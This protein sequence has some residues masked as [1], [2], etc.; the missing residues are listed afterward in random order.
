MQQ[1]QGSPPSRL[2]AEPSASYAVRLSVQPAANSARRRPW[3]AQC[4]GG[5]KLPWSS[6]LS[7]STDSIMSCVQIGRRKQELEVVL[8]RLTRQ[9]EVRPACAHA[10]TLQ[11][12]S[13]RAQAAP[14]TGPV[15]DATRA[16]HLE[17]QDQRWILAARVDEHKG[18][19]DAVYREATEGAVD[20]AGGEVGGDQRRRRVAKVP[21][22]GEGRCGA[23]R[24]WVGGRSGGVCV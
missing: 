13:T 10:S 15:K 17:H 11:N 2:S 1:V 9:W 6:R 19:E 21:G 12:C 14:A 7:G 23:K 24:G 22:R 16:V 5:W 18:R 8:N 4:R 20:G 3:A